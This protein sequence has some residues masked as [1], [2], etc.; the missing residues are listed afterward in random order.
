VAAF[1]V[2]PE[3][4]EN[5]LPDAVLHRPRPQV[6][7][8]LQP[9]TAERAAD[10]SQTDDR[11]FGGLA[12]RLGWAWLVP[13]HPVSVGGVGRTTRAVECV[14]FPSSDKFDEAAARPVLIAPLKAANL[15]SL[16]HLGP[17]GP[18]RK[19]LPCRLI[20]NAG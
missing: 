3:Q 8:I 13:F 5:R 11:P 19:P 10:D 1:D 2:W 15:I 14:E 12:G 4:V 7:A 9:P 6:A 18:H 17:A 16:K 20:A